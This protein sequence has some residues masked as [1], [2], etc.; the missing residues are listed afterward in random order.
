[1][2]RE[3]EAPVGSWR[4]RKSAWAVTGGA[5]PVASRC[6]VEADMNHMGYGG[7]AHHVPPKGIGDG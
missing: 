5:G 6:L 7:L 1:M 4:L 3:D 2:T